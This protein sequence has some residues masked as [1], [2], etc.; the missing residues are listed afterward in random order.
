MVYG[1]DIRL[2]S[3]GFGGLGGEVDKPYRYRANHEGKHSSGNDYGQNIGYSTHNVRYLRFMISG[4][5]RV[6]GVRRRGSHRDAQDAGHDA[7]DGDHGRHAHRER[8][9]PALRSRRVSP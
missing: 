7:R 8:D 1:V 6:G 9:A 5:G 3:Y 2:L 4:A